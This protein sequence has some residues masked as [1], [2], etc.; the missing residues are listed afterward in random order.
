VSFQAGLRAGALL[1][2]SGSHT[3]RLDIS[4]VGAFIGVNGTEAA[5]TAQPSVKA[6]FDGG[7]VQSDLDGDPSTLDLIQ[8]DSQGFGGNDVLLGNCNS[9]VIIGGPGADRIYGFDA[10]DVLIGDDGWVDHTELIAYVRPC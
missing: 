7:L 1:A 9:D 10:S 2:P 6:L 5:T 8:S 4:A 3:L